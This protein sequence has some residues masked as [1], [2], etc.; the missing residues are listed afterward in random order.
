[1]YSDRF[2]RLRT[3]LGLPEMPPE[4]LEQAFR[5][6]SFVREEGL[7]ELAS[8]QRLEFLGDAV[9]DLVFADYLYRA[10]PE[11]TEGQLTRLKAELVRR[12]ALA[13]VATELDFGSYLLLGRGEE[14]TGGRE[15]N[16][17]LADVVEALIGAVF[18]AGGWQAA[19]DFVITHFEALLNETQLRQNLSDAK[20]RLQELLQADGAAPPVYEVT[21]TDGPPHDRVFHVQVVFAGRPIGA[22]AGPS[23]R[24]AEQ[25]AAAAALECIEE[26]FE[27]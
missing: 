17:L 4:L 15:K 3:A 10:R 9:L 24:D 8:N 18:L 25:E 23:K 5:H 27:G 20:S 19:H 14:S 26:W 13:A 21:R 22:G 11:L 1:M 6:T 2:A 7:D 16:S 12:S